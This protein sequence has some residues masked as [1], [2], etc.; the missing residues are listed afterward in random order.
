MLP[1]ETLEEH[2]YN[3]NASPSVK[4]S[5]VCPN[6]HCQAR[7]Q[8]MWNR[9]G[10]RYGKACNWIDGN[11][12]P[13]GTI[14][15]RLNV[16]IYKKDEDYYLDTIPC[17]PL[18]GWKVKVVHH[19]RANDDGKI[20]SRGSSLEWHRPESGGV[21]VIHIWGIRMLK[22]CLREIWR[23]WRDARKN[24]KNSY[25]KRRIEDCLERAKWDN[26][27]WWRKWSASVARIALKTI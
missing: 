2:V 25:A 11:D 24:P 18:K 1:L 26:A 4:Q 9:D 17:W 10:E 21:Y 23:D 27:E 3:P 20:L 22:H 6:P 7:R 5:Y 13:F 8:V 19:N 15:R 14:S 16:E 12:A